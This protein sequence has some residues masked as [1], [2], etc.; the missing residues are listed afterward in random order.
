MLLVV[1]FVLVV[2][3]V[4]VLE[5]TELVLEAEYAVVLGAVECVCECPC[6]LSCRD[7]R[8]NLSP[9]SKGCPLAWGTAECIVAFL[10]PLP[11]FVGLLGPNLL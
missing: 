1:V 2:V 9:A 6:P 5:V 10:R 4:R 7:M 11:A 8:Q 3:A